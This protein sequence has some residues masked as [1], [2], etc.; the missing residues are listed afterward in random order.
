MNRRELIAGAVT[1]PSLALAQQTNW[2]PLTFD[3]HQ[4]NTVVVLC[5][6]IIPKTDTPG[7]KEA[8][9]NRYIDLII[10][11]GVDTQR[12]QFL[13]GLGWLDNYSVN[14]FGKTFVACDRTQQTQMVKDCLENNDPNGA[15]A[16]MRFAKSMIA[17]LYYNTQAGYQELNKGGRIPKSFACQA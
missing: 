3:A 9:V 11:D 2:T 7:A 8:N 1:V 4:N 13:D 16:F 12:T 10:T 15:P 5:E 6:I 17:R 14:R